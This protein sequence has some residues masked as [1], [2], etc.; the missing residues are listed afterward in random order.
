MRGTY[1]VE[2]CQPVCTE[3]HRTHNNM[4]TSTCYYKEPRA[5]HISNRSNFIFGKDSKN[6]VSGVLRT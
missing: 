4:C 5:Y 2:H 6:A 3:E 1:I